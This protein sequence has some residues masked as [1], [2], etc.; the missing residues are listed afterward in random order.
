MRLSNCAGERPDGC[1]VLK[2]CIKTYATEL[3]P[4][5]WDKRYRRTQ[6]NF[7]CGA[8]SLPQY[9]YKSLG[10][11]ILD[12]NELVIDA[13]SGSLPANVSCMGLSGI[14]CVAVSC[15]VLN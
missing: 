12:P 3:S 13:L 10:E 15:T 1:K 4:D 5:W 11:V 6:Y 14:S 9:P 2:R 7:T 8:F